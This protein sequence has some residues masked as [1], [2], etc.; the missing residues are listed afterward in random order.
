MK[1][2]LLLTGLATMGFAIPAIAAPAP[3][4]DG[5]ALYK[6]RCQ[7]CHG[8]PPATT[9]LAPGLVGVVGRR[10]ASADFPYSAALKASGLVW[11][12]AQLDTFLAAPAKAVPGTRMVIGVPDAA[13][14]R[15]VIA[16][17]AMLKRR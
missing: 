5:A 14:R 12:A 16:Y 13:Q 8:A 9:K 3:T 10:A 6:Q 17:L 7:M 2:S 4:P 11:T 1:L 15:A